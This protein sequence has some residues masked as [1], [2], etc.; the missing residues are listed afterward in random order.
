MELPLK[1]V[2]DRADLA[3]LVGETAQRLL[4]KFAGK[5]ENPAMVTHLRQREGLS[6]VRC[7]L[8]LE[9]LRT[10]SR[11]VVK[12]PARWASR[13]LATSTGLE[14]STDAWIA[15]YK[16]TRFPVGSRVADLCCGIGGDAMALAKR[17]RVTGVDCDPLAVLCAWWNLSLVCPC[18]AVLPDVV[19]PPDWLA[20]SDSTVSSDTPASADMVYPSR[21]VNADVTTFPLTEF[22]AIHLDPDRRATVGRTTFLEAYQPPKSTIDRMIETMRVAKPAPTS[23]PTGTVMPLVRSAKNVEYAQDA[24][25]YPRV[26]IKLAPGSTAPSDWEA[27]AELEWISRDRECRQQMVWMGHLTTIPG[28]R[29][30][31]AIFPLRDVFPLG[32]S[33][34][35]RT[36][37]V[38]EPLPASKSSREFAPLCESAEDSES[39]STVVSSREFV[40]SEVRY[41]WKTV[42]GKPGCA[43]AKGRAMGDF[44]K[45]WIIEPDVA[46]LAADLTGVVAERL[47]AE[48]LTP[49]G[50]Y[51]TTSELDAAVA[52]E[53]P[54]RCFEWMETLPND[55]RKLAATLNRRGIGR[56]E[57]KV[58]NLPMDSRLKCRPADPVTAIFGKRPKWTGNV[59]AV[60]FVLG[61]S[62]GERL[63]FLGKRILD[64]WCE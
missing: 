61:T 45:R 30:A 46:V 53:L 8:L 27:H 23:T 56:L 37:T 11:A 64:S 24:E 9:Q 2:A 40:T 13:L 42:Y 33:A 1:V 38:A 48:P 10:R 41:R 39:I 58:R 51:L 4:T 12:Y 60:L 59:A 47:T 57:C 49:D 50:A 43:K 6:E 3:W 34:E 15:A 54:V 16:A 26:A 25:M 29:R 31:T 36:A 28:Q 62:E 63:T 52:A 55:P 7:A 17:C 22:E 21:I 35:E 44:P 19:V 5:P 32:E 20:L 18:A 14:Q